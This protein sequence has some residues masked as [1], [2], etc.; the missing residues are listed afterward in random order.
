[1]RYDFFDLRTQ[2]PCAL[3][4]AGRCLADF[5]RHHLI[6]QQGKRLAEERGLDLL[7]TDG[8]PGIGCPVIASVSNTDLVLIVAEPTLSGIHDMERA[9]TLAFHFGVKPLVCINKY[10]INPQNTTVIEDFCRARGLEVVGRIPYDPRVGQALLQAKS[11][12][13]YPCGEVTGEVK[14]VWER[15]EELLRR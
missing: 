10:D 3:A 12:I 4:I 2:F 9:L 13:E 7:L 14:Q 15:A 1:M 5:P 11:V 6:R 8:P